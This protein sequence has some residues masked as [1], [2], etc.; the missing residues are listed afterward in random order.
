MHSKAATWATDTQIRSPATQKAPETIDVSG[1]FVRVPLSAAMACVDGRPAGQARFVARRAWGGHVLF[2]L[3]AI[4][5]SGSPALPWQG[6]VLCTDPESFTTLVDSSGGGRLHGAD[7]GIAVGR[8]GTSS[9][10]GG[11]DGV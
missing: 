7:A 5:V 2:G 6:V 4:A 3:T 10:R 8:T 9:R 11:G 1:A